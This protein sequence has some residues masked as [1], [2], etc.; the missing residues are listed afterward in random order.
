MTRKITLTLN[1][2]VLGIEKCLYLG[3][4]YALRDWGHARDYAEMQWKILQQ[5]KPDDYVIATEK[6]YSVKFFVEEC[7]KYLGIKNKMGGQ[8]SKR[9]R[10]NHIF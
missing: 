4:L 2:I 7:L 8:R 1:K 10:I 9:K 5:N 6:Q 3:N